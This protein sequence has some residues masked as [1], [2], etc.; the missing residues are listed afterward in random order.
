M[1][2][3]SGVTVNGVMLEEFVKDN[4]Q[5]EEEVERARL[6]EETTEKIYLN[7]HIRSKHVTHKEPNGKVKV[8]SRLEISLTKY[9]PLLVSA[10]KNYDYHK[11][12]IIIMMVERGKLIDLHKIA[13]YIDNFSKDNSIELNPKIRRA[14]RAKLG[15]VKKSELF[16]YMEYMDRK[17]PK[18]KE[19]YAKFKL[20]SEK[21]KD[22]TIEK[23]LELGSSL[24]PGQ[25][26]NPG[27]KTKSENIPPVKTSI[28]ETP[29]EEIKIPKEKQIDKIKSITDSVVSS[30][31]DI[32]KNGSLVTVQG[33][34]HIH[35]NIRS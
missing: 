11:A 16:D 19:N 2:Y 23:A 1:T 29:V 15:Y 26:Y 5:I 8:L 22:L 10:L 31:T 27:P 18:N 33:D 6:I 13:D 3:K 14:L 28:P 25:K 30:I 9:E 7:R 21:A 12:F 35:I 34:I 4:E 32:I 24:R 20:D 17:D